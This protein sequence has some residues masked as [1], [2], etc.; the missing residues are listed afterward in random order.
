MSSLEAFKYDPLPV[1]GKS[2]RLVKVLASAGFDQPVRIELIHSTTEEEYT[3]LS[4][5]WGG[6]NPQREVHANDALLTAGPNLW[7]FLRRV[8]LSP[9]YIGRQFWIDAICINQKDDQEKSVQVARMG[10]IYK[11]AH[12]VLIWLAPFRDAGLALEDTISPICE[13]TDVQSCLPKGDRL[14]LGLETKSFHSASTSV[15]VRSIC[16]QIVSH[17]YW[18]RVWIVQEFL[19]NEKRSVL[20]GPLAISWK[21][22]SAYEDFRTASRRERQ[23]KIWQ[24]SLLDWVR[25][26]FDMLSFMVSRSDAVAAYIRTER[27]D[28]ADRCGVSLPESGLV[29]QGS[30]IAMNFLYSMNRV[31]PSML[32]SIAAWR[33]DSLYACLPYM[34]GT[35]RDHDSESHPMQAV[36]RSAFYLLVQ[37]FAE[38]LCFDR[39][40]KLYGLSALISQEFPVPIDY[41]TD[42]FEL[43]YR[44]LHY[45]LVMDDLGEEYCSMAPDLLAGGLL[46]VFKIALSQISSKDA[47]GRGRNFYLTADNANA[48]ASTSTPLPTTK[49]IESSFMTFDN[50]TKVHSMTGQ[51]ISVHCEHCGQDIVFSASTLVKVL[52]LQKAGAG[53]IGEEGGKELVLVLQCLLSSSDAGLERVSANTRSDLV[54]QHLLSY[55]DPQSGRTETVLSVMD[56]VHRQKIIQNMSPD[57]LKLLLAYLKQLGQSHSATHTFVTDALN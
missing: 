50:C 18:R 32:A 5:T 36:S 31:A 27:R 44:A 8:S 22:L 37:G 1:D 48:E 57:K 20:Y 26:P 55:P 7:E 39:K 40:D 25:S 15:F 24:N 9:E 45:F 34:E 16:E 42:I 17:D 19:L 53:M 10:E 28:S 43:Y 13:F 47:K 14:Q 46:D 6:V 54:A 49:T 2:I 23:R 33:M 12:H 11:S 4:Y 41:T 29:Q 51:K 30:S 52:E 38:Q 35:F 56:E 21:A 3:A